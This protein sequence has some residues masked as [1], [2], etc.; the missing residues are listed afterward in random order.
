MNYAPTLDGME[1]MGRVFEG[2]VSL[3]C[4]NAK[5]KDTELQHMATIQPMLFVDVEL[6]PLMKIVIHAGGPSS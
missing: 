3:C 1:I 5:I 6:L 2:I 4:V